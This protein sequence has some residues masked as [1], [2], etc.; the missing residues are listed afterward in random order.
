MTATT[1]AAKPRGRSSAEEVKKKFE[2]L[3]LERL[4]GCQGVNLYAKDPDDTTDDEGLKREFAFYS[5]FP[6]LASGIT[7][8]LPEIDH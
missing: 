8:M 3:R 7:G 4:N 6:G 1:T 5:V 2:Q